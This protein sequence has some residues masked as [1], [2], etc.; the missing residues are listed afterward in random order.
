MQVSYFWI[1][2]S[3][4]CI[5]LISWTIKWNNLIPYFLANE[6]LRNV[7]KNLENYCKYESWRYCDKCHIVEPNKMLPTFGHQKSTTFTNCICTKGRYFVPMVC[8]F[9]VSF[10]LFN[11]FFGIL[12]RTP[13]DV[14]WISHNLFQ[15]SWV[16]ET[17][18]IR[19]NKSYL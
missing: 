18:S 7:T 14:T 12:L 10:I 8:F 9:L 16:R 15:S 13:I 19:R 4:T 6:T 5:Y 17:N 1:C 11:N 2:C 3:W